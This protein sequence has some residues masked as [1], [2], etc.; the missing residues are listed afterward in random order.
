MIAVFQRHWWSNNPDEAEFCLV[1]VWANLV[2]GKSSNNFSKKMLANPAFET[3]WVVCPFRAIN[4]F[5]E[6]VLKSFFD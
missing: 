4:S 2:I 1:R 3:F 6:N 5:A